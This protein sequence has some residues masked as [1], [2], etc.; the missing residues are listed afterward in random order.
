MPKK[1]NWR[2]DSKK[3]INQQRLPQVDLSAAYA[4]LSK[5][6]QFEQGILHDYQS[7]AGP[8]QQYHLSLEAEF[9]VYTGG[10]F[11][12]HQTKSK[13]HSDITKLSAEYYAKQLRLSIIHSFLAI[14][15]LGSQ[16][17][18][19]S[20]KMQEDS[21]L[22]SQVQKLKDQGK[23]TKNEVLRAKLQWSN[24]HMSYKTIQNDILIAEHRL[25]SILDLPDSISLHIVDLDL[26]LVPRAEENSELA[27]NNFSVLKHENIEIAR[28]NKALTQQD[29]NIL[30]SELRPQIHIKGQY[31][32]YYPNMKFYPSQE[33]LYG[34]GMLGLNVQYSL[35]NLYTHKDKKQVLDTQL[36][37]DE[38]SVKKETQELNEQLYAAYI[39]WNE[40][41]SQLELAQEA[42]AEASEN[43]RLVKLKYIH[44][45]SLMTELIDADNSLLD[46]ESKYIQAQINRQLQYYQLQ[47]S[48]GSI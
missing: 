34:F 29:Y 24:H 39:K 22:I 15:Y 3:I 9:P 12:A 31:G 44:H 26:N 33:Y 11:K 46:A 35:S 8:D 42:I 18:L 43:Y 38:L 48:L 36:S 19:F 23:V 30:Q 21:L 25:A 32:L 37:L 40:A 7:Y 2:K 4:R 10:R 47:F 45:L 20:H 1:F 27:L 17:N 16:K 13:I 41:N 14:Q 5:I 28:K 6:A